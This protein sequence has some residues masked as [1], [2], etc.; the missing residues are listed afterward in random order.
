MVKMVVYSHYHTKNYLYGSCT[1][2]LCIITSLYCWSI[3][4]LSLRLIGPV[5]KSWCCYNVKQHK[6]MFVVP[7]L[8]LSS[9]VIVLIK[10]AKSGVRLETP[11]QF[12]KKRKPHLDLYTVRD[13]GKAVTMMSWSNQD[14][15]WWIFLS[16]NKL[17]S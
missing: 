15:K 7:V 10:N 16:I 1:Y 3:C 17:G 14:L 6:L 13:T 2:G 11:R 12:F 4:R 9:C 8:I 5:F